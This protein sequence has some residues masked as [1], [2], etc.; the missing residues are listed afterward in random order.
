M[1]GSLFTQ[2]R[3][4]GWTDFHKKNWYGDDLIPGKFGSGRE[5]FK[6]FSST[7]V[8]GNNEIPLIYK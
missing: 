3:Q 1:N 7:A 2:S 4:N 8:H 5:M 6:Y